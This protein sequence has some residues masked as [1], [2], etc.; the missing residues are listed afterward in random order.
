MVHLDEGCKQNVEQEKHGPNSYADV[1]LKWLPY[2]VGALIIVF[3]QQI[4]FSPPLIIKYSY[5]SKNVLN[6]FK[7]FSVYLYDVFEN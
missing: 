1:C 4:M 2:T 6:L 7:T 5:S 3:M